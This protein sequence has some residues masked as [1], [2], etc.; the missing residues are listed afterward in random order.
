MTLKQTDLLINSHQKT[1]KAQIHAS[2][3]KKRNQKNR[4]SRF[5]CSLV[6]A[7]NIQL[8]NAKNYKNF[9]A[10]LNPDFTNLVLVILPYKETSFLNNDESYHKIETDSLETCIKSHLNILIL[11]IVVSDSKE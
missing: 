9:E 11:V 5:R 8:T 3:E 6:F 2:E 1:V 7:D 4:K 10:K